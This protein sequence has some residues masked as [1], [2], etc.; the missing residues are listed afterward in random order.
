MNWKRN[1][2]PEFINPKCNRQ[3]GHEWTKERAYANTAKWKKENAKS[4]HAYLASCKKRTRTATPPWVDKKSLI[5][6]YKHCPK[7]HHVDHIIPLNNSI[8][9]GLNVPWN[10]Q[11][12]EKTAN[13]IK[14]AKFDGTYDN[15][16]WRKN[17]KT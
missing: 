7:D 13:L 2:D 9:S 11:Y 16:S 17:E 14:G 6:I 12:L 5:E 1:G 4:Y 15:N 10:L 3:P 8:I